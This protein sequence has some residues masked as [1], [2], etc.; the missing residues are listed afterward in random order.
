MHVQIMLVLFLQ[1]NNIIT[2]CQT[3]LTSFD[4]FYRH[5]IATS[6][7]NFHDICTVL[8]GNETDILNIPQ[9]ARARHSLA[10]VLGSSIDASES[11]YKDLQ[12]V[13]LNFNTVASGS[14]DE[15]T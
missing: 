3:G 14:Y 2:D 8:S 1:H 11:M 9:D 6:R 12:T 5:P 15:L 7:P 4:F 10:G 13:Y